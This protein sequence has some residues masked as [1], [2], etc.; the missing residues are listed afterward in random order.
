MCQTRLVLRI[1]LIS[2]LSDVSQD[3][4]LKNFT[5]VYFAIVSHKKFTI[6]FIFL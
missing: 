1:L 2:K 3:K 6:L 5:K 4:T